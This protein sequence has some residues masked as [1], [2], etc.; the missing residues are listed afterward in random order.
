LHLTI[1]TPTYFPLARLGFLAKSVL[2]KIFAA[3]LHRRIFQIELEHPAL[4]QVPQT[5]HPITL[6]LALTTR[7]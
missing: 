6:D 1:H 5:L 7:S 3:S 4:H 2:F